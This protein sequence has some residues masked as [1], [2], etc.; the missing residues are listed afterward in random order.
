MTVQILVRLH[1]AAFSSDVQAT[2]SDVELIDEDLDFGEL[3][4]ADP[5]FL[6]G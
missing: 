1:L 3:G 4:G 5:D 6:G 2:V